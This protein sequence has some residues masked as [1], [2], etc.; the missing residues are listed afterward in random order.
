MAITTD[1]IKEAIDVYLPEVQAEL[2]DLPRKDSAITAALHR[3]SRDHPKRVADTVDANPAAMPSDWDSEFSEIIEAQW[4]YIHATAGVIE[5]Q[6]A[7]WTIDDEPGGGQKLRFPNAPVSA[8]SL[9]RVMFTLRWVSADLATFPASLE[10][11]IKVL[12]AS[13]YADMLAGFFESSA[14]PQVGGLQ[15]M[16]AGAKA[17]SYL[18]HAESLRVAY[19]AMMGIMRTPKGSEKGTTREG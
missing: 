13:I 15:L 4:P 16:D 5:K 9:A 19:Y 7:E 3:L 11:P 10:E 17:D 2:N 6:A 1:Q 14:S 18:A 12:S 8:A